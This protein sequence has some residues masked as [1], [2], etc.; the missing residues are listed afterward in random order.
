MKRLLTI[1]V[2]FLTLLPAFSQSLIPSGETFLRQLEPRDSVIVADQ[3]EYGVV[4]EDSP[5]GAQY[6]FPDVSKGFID[7]VE[8][9]RGWIADSLLT[10]KQFRAVRNG[11]DVS[12]DL[13]ASI[14]IAP[15]GEGMFYLPPIPVQRTVDGVVDTLVFDPQVLEVKAMP[16][17]TATFEMHDLKGQVRYPVTAAEILPWVAGFQ[18]FALA[19]ALVTCLVLS[20]R[21]K[22]GPEAPRE[23]AYITALRGLDRF[24][25]D[26]FWTPDKQ[27]T[28]YS[29]IT[30]TLRTYIES[31][32]DINAEE[33]TTAEIFDSL[34]T[35]Q[36]VTPDLYQD[37]KALFEL[38]DFVKFAK[39]V[40]TD[41][42][43]ANAIPVAV[44]FVT[45]TYQSQ[46]DAQAG[47][48]DGEEAVSR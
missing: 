46:L 43:N 9:V 44:R 25:G 12:V 3:L 33:M 42:D 38:S 4:I 47:T 21:K 28:M 35:C 15:F 30:D 31:R 26:K 45:S 37:T 40:A 32:F 13:R 24:R 36:D 1:A 6:A 11:E 48:D 34:K 10:P 39:M 41:E 14:V 7:S 2:A 27:K 5:R 22:E 19:V 23:P 20:R 29:G 8:V 16:V 17:D 18:L